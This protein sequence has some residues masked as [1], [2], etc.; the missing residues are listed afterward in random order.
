VLVV[1]VVSNSGSG[2]FV[3]EKPYVLALGNRNISLEGTWKMKKGCEMP[4]LPGETFVRWKPMGLYNEMIAPMLKFNIK[5]AIWYQGE[6][7]TSILKNMPK[8]F[9]L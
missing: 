7:N 4:P 9:R 5:G 2:G 3:P 1:R 8:C 6:S